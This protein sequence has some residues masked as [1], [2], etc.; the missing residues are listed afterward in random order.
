MKTI[1]IQITGKVRD[2]GFRFFVKQLAVSLGLNG[3]VSYSG[4]NR[5]FIE[6]TGTVKNIRRFIEY[7][8]IGS[9]G[10]RVDDYSADE[11]PEKDF[12]SFEIIS[13]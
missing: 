12:T 13:N 2:V 3:I 9:Y 4:E 1:R 5:L 10:S 7:S 8:Q 6:V 11:I